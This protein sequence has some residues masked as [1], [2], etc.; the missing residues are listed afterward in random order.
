MNSYSQYKISNNSHGNGDYEEPFDERL[1]N[2]QFDFIRFVENRN[3]LNENERESRTRENG[4]CVVFTG[5]QFVFLKNNNNGR[6]GHLGC[7][8][9]IFVT[10]E[11]KDIPLAIGLGKASSIVAPLEKKYLT[12]TFEADQTKPREFYHS[13][14][15]YINGTISQEEFNS[16]K[17]FYDKFADII[18]E[19]PFTFFV[20]DYSVNKS[21]QNF[22]NMEQLLTFLESRIDPNKKAFVN[23]NGE[24]NVGCPTSTEQIQ[25]EY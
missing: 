12:M 19:F 24:K 3:N 17:C 23:P 16:F 5:K 18:G 13:I 20:Y 7:F 9:R 25:K 14:R 11:G 15:F 6:S 1:I 22:T 2:T 8:A 21:N 10:M 4:A